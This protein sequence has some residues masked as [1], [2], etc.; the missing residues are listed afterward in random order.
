[1]PQKLLRPLERKPASPTKR[2]RTS[3]VLPTGEKGKRGFAV[4]KNIEVT[5]VS[6]EADGS[7]MCSNQ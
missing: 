1:M 6:H 2:D 7:P 5:T 3:P 4:F